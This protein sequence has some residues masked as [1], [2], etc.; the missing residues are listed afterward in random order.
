[1]RWKKEIEQLTKSQYVKRRGCFN[2][3]QQTLINYYCHR[4]GTFIPKGKSVRRLKLQGSNKINGFCPA[5]MKVRIDKNK[6]CKVDYID[7]H[8]GH[9]N[10]VKHL[11]LTLEE[12]KSIAEKIEQR[13]SFND[14]LKEAQL[15]SSNQR[16]NLLKKRDLFNIQ[17][18]FGLEQSEPQPEYRVENEGLDDGIFVEEVE[19]STYNSGLYDSM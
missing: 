3:K 15:K 12:R 9:D 6:K 14:I 19:V 13:I 1:M 2:T 7:Q 10:D 18:C 8:V 4:S 5:S 11:T 17:K 16:L